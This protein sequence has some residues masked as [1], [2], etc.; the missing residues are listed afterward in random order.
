M[1]KNI[2]V[3]ICALFVI[4][5]T[6]SNESKATKA[7]EKYLSE[8]LHDWESYESVS[9]GDVDSTFQM[10]PEEWDYW[11]AKN[12]VEIYTDMALEKIRK[13]DSYEGLTSRYF[14]EERKY[15]ME[16]INWA[17]DT[18]TYYKAVVDSFMLDFEPYFKGWEVDH[19]YRANNAMG[20]KTLGHYRFFFDEEFNE[21]TDVKDLSK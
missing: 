11:T 21:V 1:K 6:T 10:E 14:L 5:C 9:I 13:Y 17:V 16:D 15:L 19:S 7:I 20:N 8:R 3:L 18:V 4:G 12:N 2:S